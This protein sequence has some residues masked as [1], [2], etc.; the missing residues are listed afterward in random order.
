MSD[1]LVVIIALL[2]VF[3]LVRM[4]AY[5]IGGDIFD[6]RK[7]RKDLESAG[8]NFNHNPYLPLLTTVLT[9]FNAELNQP[10]SSY[11]P[12]VNVIIPAFNEDK[13]IVRSIKSV[14][15]SDYPRYRL[16]IV[17]DG[18]TD[19]T[20][21]RVRNFID[22]TGLKDKVK[23]VYQ[24]N[25]GKGHALN[26][27]INNHTKSGLV[28]VLDADSGIAKDAISKGVK[29]F[30]DS[31]VMA[32][33]ANI[34]VMPDKRLMGLIQEFEYII[35]NR[36]RKSY[37]VIN[38]EYVIGGVGSMFRRS[39]LRK[40]GFYDT[41]TITED[42]DLTF[43]IIKLGNKKNR[44]TYGADI[45]AYTEGVMTFR[46]LIK[47]RF[48]WKFG[49]YQAYL[50][51]RSLFFNTDKKYDRRLTVFMLPYTLFMDLLFFF[52]PFVF[53]FF[54]GL[55][56]F[57]SGDFVFL[58]AYILITTYVGWHLIVDSTIERKR[59]L[60]LLLMAPV[61]YFML[62]IASIVEYFALVDSLIK[63]PTIKHSIA[64]GKGVWT[65]VERSG[66]QQL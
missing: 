15:S 23:L 38:S 27:A 45:N 24:Q 29:Y 40:V 33:C 22:Q 34:K 48:R 19:S 21:K 37:N 8:E 49:R 1:T 50:K 10:S 12:L 61:I 42:L 52:E 26:N 14:L 5:L 56:V 44:I 60:T 64:E 25:A 30:E 41:D 63:L 35:S 16:I 18:S 11:R 36:I 6:L 9:L 43:K 2:A 57:F 53:L 46:A 59:K 66:Q 39:V 20:Y 51:H 4:A 17:D 3:N 55:A 65:H 31:T 58:N 32:V 47:Q 62:F 13:V 54:L 7:H 28:M